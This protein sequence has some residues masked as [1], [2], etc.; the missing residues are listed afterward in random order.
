MGCARCWVALTI[1]APVAGPY[2]SAGILDYHNIFDYT[3]CLTALIVALAAAHLV[4]LNGTSRLRTLSFAALMGASV[5]FVA[6]P[7]IGPEVGLSLSLV[8]SALGGFRIR[9]L[10]VAHGG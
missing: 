3:F 6:V 7:A 1:A 9:A 2:D 4:P 8:G 10:P 5:C